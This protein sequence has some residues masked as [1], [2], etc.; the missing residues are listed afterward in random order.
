MET[1]GE[2]SACLTWALVV[3]FKMSFFP[4]GIK[5]KFTSATIIILYLYIFHMNPNVFLKYESGH[6]HESIFLLWRSH[7]PRFV[8]LREG[9][10]PKNVCVHLCFITCLHGATGL[11]VLG[12]V[13]KLHTFC[14]QRKLIFYDITAQ[15]C[16]FKGGWNVSASEGEIWARRRSRM[17]VLFFIMLEIQTSWP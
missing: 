14:W 5:R 16:I 2:W 11:L 8:S 17:L 9:V 12:L 3:V 13:S 1:G 6:K 4:Y 10:S 7:P 15:T